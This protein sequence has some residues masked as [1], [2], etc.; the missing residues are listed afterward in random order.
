MP[1]NEKQYPIFQEFKH[2]Q[3]DKILRYIELVYSRDSELVK[4]QFDIV[5]LKYA[6][7]VDAGLNPD[8][9]EVKAIASLEDR[10]VAALIDFYLT[11]VQNNYEHVNLMTNLELFIEYTS[12]VRQPINTE[13]EE[14]KQ[15]V[16]FEKKAKLRAELASL[17]TAIENGFKSIYTV[18]DI[19]KNKG[20]TV[21]VSAP[22]TYGKK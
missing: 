9:D 22:E 11:R 15:L 14:D 8:S 2:P 5:D 20:R 1:I 21:N 17:Q 10:E 3:K 6:A 16:A 4:K 18:Y 12:R 13:L 19:E 7:A